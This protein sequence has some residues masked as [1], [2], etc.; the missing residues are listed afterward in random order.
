MAESS[1]QVSIYFI[2]LL[3]LEESGKWANNMIN[4]TK[5]SRY[6]SVIKGGVMYFYDTLC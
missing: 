3:F 4:A 5:L 6:I 1:R 2:L